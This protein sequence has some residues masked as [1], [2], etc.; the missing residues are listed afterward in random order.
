MEDEVQRMQ[1][2]LKGLK[3]QLSC[4]A[5]G[6]KDL[7]GEE[8]ANYEQISGRDLG[9]H[10]MHDSQLGYGN[11]SPHARSSEHNF[12]IAMRAID[13]ELEM[14]IMIHLVKE[15]QEMMFEMEEI[16]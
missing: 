9:G 4:L 12:M 10:S 7:K 2:A 16:M 14:I 15:F 6:V 1:Q 5:K 3:Q 11:F 13:L 8:R